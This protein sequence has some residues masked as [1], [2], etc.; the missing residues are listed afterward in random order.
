[1]LTDDQR[2]IYARMA[3][4]LIP[5]AEG[6]PSATEAE[7]P[8]KWIDDALRYRPDLEQSF[9]RAISY[10]AKYEAKQAVEV[11]NKEDVEAFDTLGV[12]T[13]GAYFLNPIVKKLIGYPGQVPSPANDDVDKYIE[14]LTRVVERGPIYRPTVHAQNN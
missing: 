4:I 1:M 2:D 3:D 9:I 10:G 5:S 13:S 8:S 11:L 14:M 12:L 7:I 6:M